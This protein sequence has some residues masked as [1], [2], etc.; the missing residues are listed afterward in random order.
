MG[1]DVGC[2]ASRYDLAGQEK[3]HR[4]LSAMAGPS[5]WDKGRPSAAARK[6]QIIGG[7]CFGFPRARLV[8]LRPPLHRRTDAPHG[9]RN[10][11][12]SRRLP[13]DTN[14]K[15]R[16]DR[17]AASGRRPGRIDP[18][19]RESPAPEHARARERLPANRQRDGAPCPTCVSLTARASLPLNSLGRS[20]VDRAPVQP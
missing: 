7:A 20:F 11:L 5:R 4:E 8:S 16:L 19:R 3:W 12:P 15:L 9:R 1:K 18:P 10:G 6:K 14:A 17:R 2:I 13:C